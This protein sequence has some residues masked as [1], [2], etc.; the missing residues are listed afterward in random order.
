MFATQ[1]NVLNCG[2]VGEVSELTGKMTQGFILGWPA[3]EQ[4]FFTLLNSKAGK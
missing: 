1:K 3:S 2:I 4:Q